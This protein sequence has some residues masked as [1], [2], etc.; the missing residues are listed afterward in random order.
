M[1]GWDE[2]GVPTHGRLIELNIEWAA[3]YLPAGK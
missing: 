3:Q 2:N 1:M